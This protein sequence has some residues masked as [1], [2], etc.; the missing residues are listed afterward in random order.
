MSAAAANKVQSLDTATMVLATMRRRGISG[1]PRN[2]EL[3]Y[4]ALNA[5][6]PRLTRDFEQLGR[7]PAQEDLDA[8]GKMHFP[9]HHRN[10]VVEGAHD[11]IS[12]ELEGMLRL[13][14][15]EQ[16]SL[17]SYSKL[18]GE[19]YNRI[20]SKS[21]S[22]ADIL[23]SVIGVL[24]NAT[25]DT[26]EK[27]KIVVEHMV[28]R[29]R[30]MEQV[31]LELDEYKRIANTD[32]LTRL[33]NRRAFDEVLSGIY[34]NPR[35]AMYYA[36]IVADID[37]FKKFNDTYGHPVGDRVLGVVAAV[38][39]STLRKDVFVSRTGGEEFAVV[40]KGTSLE[41]TLEIAE[42]IRRAVE[43]TPLKNQKTGVD[44]GPITLSLGI[45]MASDA[46]SAEELYNKAD[47]ALYTAKNFGR[48]RVQ[49][50]NPD[51]NQDFEKNW[52]IYK[53]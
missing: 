51:L 1:L 38:M 15:Q 20:S 30:E 36:L 11:K 37:F 21:A 50:Y 40:L 48:N 46:Q 26:M 33:S 9:H 4:E 28:E 14:K 5:S 24:S 10:G 43:M 8:L 45:C 44:Y 3:V 53:A 18:L 47:V 16:S 22:S 35:E 23:S 32:P 17:E 25:G 49:V 7:N 2:Y 12:G 31:K 34:N 39:K 41:T 19:T 52:A 29:A 42:R 6:N 27:G 13:L